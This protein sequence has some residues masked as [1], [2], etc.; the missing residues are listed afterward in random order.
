MSEIRLAKPASVLTLAFFLIA[1]G[2]PWLQSFAEAPYPSFRPGEL[3]CILP[4][5]VGM[6][7]VNAEYG[8]VVLDQLIGQQMFLLQIPEGI[9]VEE[10]LPELSQDPRI[11]L[12]EPNYFLDAPEAQKLEK[13]KLKQVSQGFLDGVSPVEYFGQPSDLQIHLTEAHQYATGTGVTV[14]VIDAGICYDHP[15]LF[16]RI[17][18]GGYDFVDNDSDPTD[19]GEGDGWGHGCFV[20]GIITLVAPDCQVLPLRVLN[21]EGRG[22]SFNVAKAIIYATD[23]DAKVVNLSL[24]TTRLSQAV[25]LAVAYASGRGVLPVASAGNDNAQQPQFPASDINAMGVAA[26]DQN[27]IKADFSNYGWYVEV[28]APGV[29]IFSILPDSQYGTWSGTSFASALVS[30]TAVLL[31]SVDPQ[32]TPNEIE[33]ALESGA[34]DIDNLNPGY[35]NRLGEGRIDALGAIQSLSGGE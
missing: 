33:E 25:L 5:G 29:K 28:C 35:R 12:C 24:G 14:A 16:G 32:A 23:Q 20:S 9:S 21:A 19:E 8:T 2:L 30:G 7:E 3:I 6:D 22:T 18:P 15:A 10:I 17:A 34:V 1:L 4:P 31:F 26:V 27:D 13:P 11:R